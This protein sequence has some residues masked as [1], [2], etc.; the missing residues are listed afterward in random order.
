MTATAV[1]AAG[2]F[3]V[4]LVSLLGDPLVIVGLGIV[5]YFFGDWLPVIGDRLD[6]DRGALLFASI[7]GAMALSIT[8]KTGFA[9]ERPPGAADLP[10]ASGMPEF[11]EGLY[12]RIVGP[13]GYAFPSGHATAAAVGWL[14]LALAFRKQKRNRPLVLAGGI[15]AAIAASRVALGVHRPI[16]VVVGTAVGLAYLL[17]VFEV[18]ERPRG[19]FGLAGLIGTFS[20]VVIELSGDGLLAVGVALGTAI[21]AAGIRQRDGGRWMQAGLATAAVVVV[22]AATFVRTGGSET[23][24]ALVGLVAGA[25][26]VTV[27]RSIHGVENE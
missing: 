5:V 20:P 19:A 6:A 10:G 22:T 12:T 8:L 7:V 21:G 1:E 16:E 2:W 11:I 3:G 26:V 4:S 18:L 17:V 13:G 24:V 23:L 9:L 27:R 14:G 25:L 15:V